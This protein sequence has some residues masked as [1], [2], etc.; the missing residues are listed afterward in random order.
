MNAMRKVGMRALTITGGT[1]IFAAGFVAAGR[2]EPAVATQSDGR[3]DACR[4]MS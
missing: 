3:I 4:T 2:L 1:L